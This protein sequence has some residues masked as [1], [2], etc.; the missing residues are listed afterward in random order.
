[1]IV[2]VQYNEELHQGEDLDE[3]IEGIAHRFG[4]EWIGSGMFMF[5]PFP[6]DVELDVP[7]DK[8]DAL[9]EALKETLP[10]TDDI[11]IVP[12]TEE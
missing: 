1:M 9:V 6:R 10:A 7:D 2:E 4:A 12:I 5:P 11:Q 8:A 3:V